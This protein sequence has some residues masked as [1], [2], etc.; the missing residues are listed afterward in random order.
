[1]QKA[2]PDTVF[3]AGQ[4]LDAPPRGEA[5]SLRLAQLAAATGLDRQTLRQ[6]LAH[7][8]VL[9]QARRHQVVH[10]LP[11]VAATFSEIGEERL[12]LLGRLRRNGLACSAS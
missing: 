9:D 5:W 1:M 11:R 10:L 6:A 2:E 8:P 4:F 3:H 7:A 12:N